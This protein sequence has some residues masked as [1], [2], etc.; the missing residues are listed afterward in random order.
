MSMKYECGTYFNVFVESGIAKPTAL[1]F[2]FLLVDDAALPSGFLFFSEFA[3]A[4]SRRRLTGAA[5]ASASNCGSMSESMI[6]E[7]AFD[8]ASIDSCVAGGEE[9]VCALEAGVEPVAP[10]DV[11]NLAL[12]RAGYPAVPAEDVGAT[13]K[14]VMGVWAAASLC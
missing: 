10:G 12:T 4:R 2:C 5:L 13:L 8:V 14:A 7:G 11:M 1:V 3:L 9:F 6:G